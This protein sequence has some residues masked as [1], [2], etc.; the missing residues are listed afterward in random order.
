MKR[1]SVFKQR[2]WLFILGAFFLVFSFAL[3]GCNGGGSAESDSGDLYIGLTDAPGDFLSYQ[4]DITSL[5]LTKENNAV[6]Q[7]L[8]EET[9]LDFTEYTE[10]TELL[11]AKTVPS[12]IYTEITMAL[13]FANAVIMVEDENGDP[14]Q[15][16]PENIV[17]ENGNQITTLNV[18]LQFPDTDRLVIAPGIPAHLTLD[19]DLATSNQVTFDENGI[20]TVTVLPNLTAEINPEDP[21][22]HRIRGPLNE[23]NLEQNEFTLYLRPFWKKINRE[24]DLKFGE[25]TVTVDEDTIYDIDGTRYEGD[26]GLEALDKLDQYTGVIALGELDL[27]EFPAKF[28]AD[29]V[30]AGSSIPG[31]DMDLL[32]GSVTK[33]NDDDGTFIVKGFAADR[34]DIRIAIAQEFEVTLTEDAIVRKEF[35]NDVFGPDDISVGQKVTIFGDLE[36]ISDDDDEDVAG[37]MDASY[38]LLNLTTIRGDAVAVN[39]GKVYIDLQSIDHWGSDTFT[40]EEGIDP[41]NLGVDTGELDLS[42]INAGDPLKIRGFFTNQDTTDPAFT[43]K[44]IIA[45]KNVRAR[46]VVNWN[47]ATDEAFTDI[48]GDKITLDLDGAGIFH[49]VGRGFV[50]TDLKDC[51][52]PALAPDEDQRGFYVIKEWFDIDFYDEFSDFADALAARIDGGDTVAHLTASGAYNDDT[53]VMEADRITVTLR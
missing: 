13:D 35:S 25:I 45:T 7:T 18:T 10:M 14:V 20:P 30:R 22:L 47:P 50:I 39:A 33:I 44:T 28:H 12:G 31:G 46:M 41:A 49:H 19:F 38:V 53:C 8:P 48:T 29:E 27:T 24:P 15:V 9:T 32:R 1:D 43:A 51:D 5:T 42:D 2:H 34:D 16:L 11:T 37:R 6:V 3:A 52:S 26:A 23:V 40:F 36:S 17:D 21:K 4:V